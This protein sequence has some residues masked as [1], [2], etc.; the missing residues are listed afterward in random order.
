MA[1]LLALCLLAGCSPLSQAEQI[2][3]GIDLARTSCKVA[4]VY[5]TKVPDDLK[6]EVA[7]ICPVLEGKTLEPSE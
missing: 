7:E 1:K 3:Y 4:G 2:R 6:D 5:P